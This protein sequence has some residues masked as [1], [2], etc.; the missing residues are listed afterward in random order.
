MPNSSYLCMIPVLV[1]SHECCNRIF[2]LRKLGYIKYYTIN[3]L[4]FSD[5]KDKHIVNISVKQ[6]HCF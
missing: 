3:K 1:G 5:T 4:L 2:K 6:L